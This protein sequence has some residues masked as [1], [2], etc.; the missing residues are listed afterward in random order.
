[1]SQFSLESEAIYI[2]R[3]VAAEAEN[4]VF[5]Y[6]VGKDSAVMLHLARKAFYPANPP[7]KFLH[8]DTNWKFKE[9]IAFRDRMMSN[10]GY[11]SR[12]Y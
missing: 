12:S 8:V 6:S 5:L 2:F 9:M 7:F 10:L 3:E 1:M 11:T 4:P